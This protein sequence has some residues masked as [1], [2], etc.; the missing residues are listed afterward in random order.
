V[1]Y[2]T[3][4]LDMKTRLNL[5]LPV[6]GFP[7]EGDAKPGTMAQRKQGADQQLTLFHAAL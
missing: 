2:G 5:D 4:R 7:A 6:A 1:R 3:F